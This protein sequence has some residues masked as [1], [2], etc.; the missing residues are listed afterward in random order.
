MDKLRFNARPREAW[1]KTLTES[2]LRIKYGVTIVGVKRPGEEFTHA[3][4]NTHVRR[5]DLLIVS[6]P[7]DV[8][9]KFAVA[10]GAWTRFSPFPHLTM[11]QQT[12]GSVYLIP[13]DRRRLSPAERR[14]S[15]VDRA[16]G[17]T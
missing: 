1:D 9:E 4:P 7:A 8:I 16:G 2:A 11:T 3:L 15:P 10:S 13:D 12:W 14:A 5:G 17:A 6:G